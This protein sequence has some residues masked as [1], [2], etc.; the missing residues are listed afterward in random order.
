MSR[1]T[2]IAIRVRCPA[3]GHRVYLEELITTWDARRVYRRCLYC[4]LVGGGDA[5]VA[6]GAH[7]PPI[8]PV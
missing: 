3:C 8:E 2:I 6:E 1:E 4:A 5:S 7:L